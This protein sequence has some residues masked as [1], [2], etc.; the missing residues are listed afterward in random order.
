MVAAVLVGAAA[1]PWSGPECIDDRSY[2]EMIRGI[3]LHGLPYTQDG[4]AELLPGL[5][6]RWNVSRDGKL[7]GTYPPL[8]PYVAAPFYALGGARAVL[9]LN[10]GLLAVLAL[11]AFALCRRLTGDP[12]LGT[13]AAYASL[14]AG[15]IWNSALL[16]HSFTL[17]TTAIVWAVF[18]AVCALE[19]SL[20]R[21][22]ALCALS[23]VL[24]GLAAGSHLLAFPMLIGLTVGWAVS[25]AQERASLRAILDRGVLLR[26]VATILGAVGPLALVSVV[27]HLRFGTWNPITYGPCPWR[28]CVEA[29][30]RQEAMG[31]MLAHAAPVIL[32][33][34][35]TLLAAWLFRHLRYGRILVGAL[36]LIALLP[37]TPLQE[38]VLSLAEVGWGYLVDMSDLALTMQPP[39]ADGLG[40]FLGRNVVRSALQAMPLVALA[41]L[42]RPSATRR[43]G[44][45]L[46]AIPTVALLAALVLRANL[47]LDHALGFPYLSHRYVAPVVPLLAALALI[48]VRDLPWKWHH[49]ELAALV[50]IGLWLALRPSL[51]DGALWR[52]V[53]LLRVPLVIA[54]A[55]FALLVVARRSRSNRWRSAAAAAASIAF[56]FT[57]SVAV[58]VDLRVRLYDQSGAKR[59]VERVARLTPSRFAVVGYLCELDQVLALRA[60]R[61]IQFADLA[62]LRDRRDLGRLVRRW[63]R[64]RRPVYA[65]IGGRE[66]FEQDWPGI[67]I[68]WVD[69]EAG[70]ARVRT[71]E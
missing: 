33:A 6:P 41:L 13:A 32:W 40:H 28:A 68:D 29:G 49:F 18:F 71:E 30:L 9:M 4:P 23:G 43:G 19:G 17:A 56:A 22:F 21:Q 35:C 10:V 65:V 14:L 60:D 24:G 46:L 45:L 67:R 7:W 69:W 63:D 25:R 52:R 3:S 42:A 5:Q 2:L 61:D 47:P 64:E 20:R 58:L 55:A 54:V 53:V 66:A 59:Y 12:L 31:P 62:E 37:P 48:A 34:G 8:Y 39:P 44:L 57:A 27:N 1:V 26:T 16:P 51:D 11:G 50:I 38:R 15:P 70:L 36:C